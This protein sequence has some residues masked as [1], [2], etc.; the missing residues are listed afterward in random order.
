MPWE[1]PTPPPD[2]PRSLLAALADAYRPTNEPPASPRRRF[3]DALF[4]AAVGIFCSWAVH[5]SFVNHDG[6]LLS[7]WSVPAVVLGGTLCPVALS[8]THIPQTLGRKAAEFWEGGAFTRA[9]G[10]ASLY[11]CASIAWGIA[12]VLSLGTPPGGR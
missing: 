8:L 7:S 12:V 3:T 1:Q 11:A 10:A 5:Q 4:A 9:I 2:K 6:W